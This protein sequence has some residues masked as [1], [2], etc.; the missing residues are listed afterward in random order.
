MDFHDYV[1]RRLPPLALAREPE[2]VDELA[3]HLGDVYKDARDEGLDHEAALAR[4]LASLPEQP[5]TLSREIASAS[6]A[7]PA[8]IVQRWS[9]AASEPVES[10]VR[11]MWRLSMLSDIRQDV[12]YALRM[13]ARTPAF[14][15]VVVLTLA[16]GIGANAAIFSAVDAILLRD[17]PVRDPARV[18]SVYRTNADG[19]RSASMSYPLYADLRDS[20][21]FDGLVAFASI[22]AAYDANGT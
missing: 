12:R 20:S 18:V 4:A 17:A 3:Q 9:N 19:S 10:D 11:S 21:A 2:I 15:L 13:L 14:T 22:A 8:V 1:R 7:L 6:H 5:E 16:L